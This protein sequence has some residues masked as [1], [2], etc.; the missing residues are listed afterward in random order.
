MKRAFIFANGRMEAPP[1]ILK[2]INPSD[3]IIAADGGTRHC[4]SLDLKPNVIIGDLDSLDSGDIT[5]YQQAG[6]EIIQHPSHK[7]ETDLELALQ[8]AMEYEITQ[9]YIIGGLGARWDMTF[10]N[11]LLAAHPMFSQLAIRLQDGS[12]ELVILRG[13]GQIKIDGKPGIPISLIP[14]AGD[15]LGITTYGLEYPLSNETLYFGSPRGVSNSIQSDHAQVIITEGILLICLQNTDV[16]Q[17]V[18]NI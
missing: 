16:N 8:L 7:D 4:K 12:Q 18:G 9:V 10:A 5:T 6:V 14:I 3:L 13:K 15:A 1:P 17:H 11:V 2:G